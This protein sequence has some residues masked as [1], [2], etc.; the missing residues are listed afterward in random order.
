MNA[1]GTKVCVIHKNVPALIAAVTS[2][3]GTAG[4]NIDNM[5]N[6]SKKDYAYTMLDIA[7]TVNADIIS[8]IS[9]IDGVIRVRVIG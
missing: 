3:F 9:A 2:A 6:A 8:S 4:L 7:G 1:A 5:V